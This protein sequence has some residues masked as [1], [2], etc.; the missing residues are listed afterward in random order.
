MPNCSRPP[1]KD[2]TA[3]K[4]DPPGGSCQD[5][6]W[7]ICSPWSAPRFLGLQ[8]PCNSAGCRTISLIFR[9][10]NLPPEVWLIG[11]FPLRWGHSADFRSILLW[12]T[13]Q[14]SPKWRD[15]FWK[16][17]KICWTSYRVGSRFRVNETSQ[18]SESYSVQMKAAMKQK[19]LAILG[20]M[21]L[22]KTW[23]ALSIRLQNAVLQ[24]C[25]GRKFNLEPTL[26]GYIW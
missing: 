17:L 18:I 10:R 16:A 1:Y 2:Q 24:A 15:P 3:S 22:S 5:P 9:N 13:C 4:I 23:L 20:Q 14:A 7:W 6:H 11:P 25:Y 19:K 21:Y 8:F 12:W 26:I